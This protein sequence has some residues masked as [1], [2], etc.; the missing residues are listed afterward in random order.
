M[1]LKENLTYLADAINKS[2][3]IIL[4]GHVNPDGDSIGSLIGMKGYLET[5][6]KTVTA[7]VP[8]NYPDFLE[9]LDPEKEILLYSSSPAKVEEKV[10]SAHLIICMD[11]N[12]LK[13]IDALGEIIARAKG[14]KILIDHHPGHDDI[15][16]VAY[17]YPQMSSTC[18]LAYWIIKGLMEIYGNS[19]PL[20]PA[21][22][23][24]TGMMTDTNN[25]ANS[26]L[27][28]TFIMAGELMEA[29]VDKEWVQRMVF[30]GYSEERMRLM[31]YMLLQN[32]KILPQYNAAVM[33]LTKEIK[34]RFNF[35]DGDSEGFVNLA[36]N[37]KNIKISALF[38]EGDE[39]IRVSLRSKDDFSVN[40]LSRAFFNGGGHERAA[41]GR[42]FIP[43]EEVG[44]YFAKSLGEFIEKEK[45][46]HLLL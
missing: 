33:I 46:A 41:G 29:G 28:S 19:L 37:I 22:A 21:T 7:V 39:F 4:V 15:F 43:I 24:Y 27:P 42:L 10:A 31:G 30:G 9:F 25:F 1:N 35:T 20:H 17:S 12:S 18:E 26:V 16:E 14:K 23:L 44:D 34:E 32:M 40:R 38:T 8:N 6:G 13:R 45:Q 11:F 36:L 3:A 5:L 2:G